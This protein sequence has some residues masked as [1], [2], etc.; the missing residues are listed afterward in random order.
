[1]SRII[2][3]LYSYKDKLLRDCVDSILENQSGSN[4]IDIHVIDKNNMNRSDS[5][6][7]TLYNH[8]VWDTVKNK[9][10]SR[11][12]IINSSDADYVCYIDGTKNFIKD[13]DN[14]YISLLEK[15]QI[16]SGTSEIVFSNTDHKFF[17]N[18]EKIP[19]KEKKLT[20][21]ID[22]SFIFTTFDI[23]KS[24]P[25]LET[26]KHNGESEILSL[27]CFAEGIDIFCIPYQYITYT[28]KDI[29]EHDYIPFSINHNYNYVIDVFKQK[30]NIFFEE[31][32]DIDKFEK[33]IGYDF[34]KLSHHPFPENDIEY[35][36]ATSLD[37]IDGKRFFGGIKSIY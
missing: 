16:L 19:A 31:E 14:K 30:G 25:S 7:D 6:G 36:P 24:L 20:G 4:E 27:F 3:I 17:C 26:L 11:I 13:W 12:N 9:F 34:S 23:F 37:D 32:V 8:E 10:T 21:W 35:D 22:P 33:F 28:G 1:M 5:F 18:Y 15:N 29:S 2:V